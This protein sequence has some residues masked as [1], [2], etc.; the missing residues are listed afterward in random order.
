M[1]DS[2][3]GIGRAR[4]K[5]GDLDGYL[6]SSADTHEAWSVT[7]HHPGIDAV[8]SVS[9]GAWIVPFRSI[10]EAEVLVRLQPGSRCRSDPTCLANAQILP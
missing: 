1:T 4:E 2:L 3:M 9:S 10:R 5:L 6:L 7:A 8:V